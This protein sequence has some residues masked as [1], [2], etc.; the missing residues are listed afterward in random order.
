MKKFHFSV[1]TKLAFGFTFL[2]AGVIL[3]MSF[4][5]IRIQIADLLQQRTSE[6]KRSHSF[7]ERFYSALNQNPSAPES[8]KIISSDNPENAMQDKPKRSL[9]FPRH[10]YYTIYKIKDGITEILLTNEESFPILP[11]TDNN[12]KRHHKSAFFDGEDLNILY[13]ANELN[14]PENSEN[15]KYFLQVWYD[16]NTD[17]ALKMKRSL[18]KMLLISILP[19]LAVCFFISYFIVKYSLSPVVKITKTAKQLSSSTLDTLLPVN[20]TDDELDRLAVTFN[21]LFNRLK[22]DFDR[23]KQF[24]SD[25]SHELKTP[26]A[27]ILGQTNLLRRWGKNDPAQLDKSIG[28]ILSEA[29]S[30]QAIIENLL[31]MSRLESHRVI[32]AKENFPASELITHIHEEVKSLSP[33]ASL[34]VNV[35]DKMMLYS[36]FELLHQVIMIVISNSIKFS[37]KNL[38]LLIDFSAETNSTYK[39][40]IT[41][42]DNG[43]GF[44]DDI[45]EH[46]FERFYRGDESHTRGKGGCGL[47]LSIA[48]TIMESL[49]GEISAEKSH[50]VKNA[51]EI[52][53]AII[54]LKLP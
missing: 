34:I 46:I 2:L 39:T 54:Q 25:V 22:L 41:I 8:E 28:T 5:F 36:D 12:S 40:V 52:R 17:F 32:P 6:L 23:E 11:L 9:R 19:L 45:I 27:V 10:Q 3:A 30:M 38:K 49:G 31:Q 7:T 29:K 33:D 4:L 50:N 16:M 44:G 42:A 48:K 26:V 43:P 14:I 20:G 18:P 1:P 37:D 21:E 15:E 13:Y 24:T 47:G 35:P 51:Q 53:G